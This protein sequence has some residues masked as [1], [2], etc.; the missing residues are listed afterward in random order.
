MT[1][2]DKDIAELAKKLLGNILEGALAGGKTIDEKACVDLA[3]LCATTL[4]DKLA[5]SLS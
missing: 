4:V 5:D 1:D 3:L 2:R